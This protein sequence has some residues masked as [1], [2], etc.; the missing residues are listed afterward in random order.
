MKPVESC[1][2]SW[3]LI[4]TFG[5]LGRTVAAPSQCIELDQVRVAPV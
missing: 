4:T 3:T 2:V 5:L 1:A